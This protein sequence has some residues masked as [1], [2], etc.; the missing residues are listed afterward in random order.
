[1]I[2]HDAHRQQMH[3]DALSKACPRPDSEG[4]TVFEAVM[5]LVWG[6]TFFWT[7]VVALRMALT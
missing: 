1:M 5:A 6:G 2:R 4:I 3:D 7:V